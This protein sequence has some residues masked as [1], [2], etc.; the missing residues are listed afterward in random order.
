MTS[1]H[2]VNNHSLHF[3][4]VFAPMFSTT[5]PKVLPHIPRRPIA[6]GFTLV[7]LLVVI[8]IVGIL[9][10]LLLPAVQQ[11]R[12]AARR[13]QCASNIKQVALAVQNYEAST[14]KLP[15]AGTYGD[16]A[17]VFYVD[18]YVRIDLKSG[19][20]YSWLVALLPYMEE[21]A[22][23]DQIDFNKHITQNPTNP[24]D[25]QPGLLLCPSD[26]AR[27]RYFEST[28]TDPT[29]GLPM[30]FGKANYAAYSNPFHVD[31]WFYSGAIW[32]YG[33]RLEQ[34]I[35]GTA[36]TLAIAEIRTRD[37]AG[38]QRGAWA[39]PWSG[40]SLLA[41]DFHPTSYGKELYDKA[42]PPEGFEP[43]KLSLGLTQYPNSQN[44]DVLYECPEPAAAQFERMPCNNAWSPPGYISAAPRSQHLGGVNAAFLDG[45][46]GF[47]PNDIDEY[48]MLWMTSTND[49]EIVAERY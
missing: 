1:E 41:F 20:N 33:R 26:G 19:T 2:C 7:E 5:R 9:V 47:L 3:E 30:R 27:G 32:L 34:V 4:S 45:H 29:T 36:T 14:K 18:A 37:H 11:A 15:A 13:I 12:E 28:E 6:R 16:P 25:A 23:Y 17:S 40:S 10:A 39:L 21:Q 43:Y 49:G 24:Q 35:D 31:S 48:V 8:A 22:V 38:D 42:N 44:P 46:V